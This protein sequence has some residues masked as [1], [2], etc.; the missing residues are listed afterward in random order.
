MI[1]KG[2]GLVG[3]EGKFWRQG[4]GG[5]EFKQKISFSN[6]EENYFSE[7]LLAKIYEKKH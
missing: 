2:E 6:F 7:K 1:R 4:E 5:G 3:G